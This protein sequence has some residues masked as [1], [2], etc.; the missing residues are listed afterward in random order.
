MNEFD[1]TGEQL[2]ILE[3]RGSG[4]QQ[5][6]IDMLSKGDKPEWCY[7]SDLEMEERVWKLS[8]FRSFQFIYIET[9][10][11]TTHYHLTSSEHA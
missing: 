7:F 9:R 4:L 3:G 10:L 1:N 6:T 8:S 2:G 5:G 11:A